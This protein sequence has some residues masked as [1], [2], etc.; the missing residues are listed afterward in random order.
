[1]KEQQGLID[2]EYIIDY[3]DNSHGRVPGPSDYNMVFALK[4]DTTALRH[5][6]PFSGR[7]DSLPSLA[8]WSGLHLDSATWRTTS[9][10]MVFQGAGQRKVIYAR[11]GIVLAHYST[12]PLQW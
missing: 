2:A 4:V 8:P 6:L 5:W 1:M 3:H 11:E 10:P 9:S 12:G 7:L